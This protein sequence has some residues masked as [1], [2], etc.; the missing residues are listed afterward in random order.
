LGLS[1]TL[2]L[3]CSPDEDR[4][5]A[6][7][8]NGGTA[9][10]GGATTGSGGRGGSTATTGGAPASEAG[11]AGD[12]F[13]DVPGG[14]VPSFEDPLCDPAA[15]YGDEEPVELPGTG[16]LTVLGITLDERS[17]LFVRGSAQA[18]ALSISDR[19]GAAEAFEASVR[20]NELD[21]FG[22]EHGAALSSDALSLVLVQADGRAFAE[23]TRAQRGRGFGRPDATRF[24]LLNRDAEFSGAHISFPLLSS[25][26]TKLYYVKTLVESRVAVSVLGADDRFELPNVIDEY[27]L[28]GS[29]DGAKLI[30]GL[31]SDERSIYFY[32][33]AS[34][35]SAALFRSRPEGPFYDP[36]EY[37]ERRALAPNED[38]SALYSVNQAGNS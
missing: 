30:S 5:A 3:A 17:V 15:S 27:T 24:E 14:G 32:D 2:F 8:A 10:S 1:L 29:E 36:V 25:D 12:P 37:G 13:G 38:C 35:Q 4:P 21:A 33:E 20:L 34:K 26:G 11:S 6:P 28:G 22:L 7:G 9:A 19:D 31:A 16:E 23:L 18:G